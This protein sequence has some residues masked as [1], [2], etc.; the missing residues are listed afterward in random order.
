M[1]S[2]VK[3][4]SNDD[5]LN[6]MRTEHEKMNEE[7]EQ[8]LNQLNLKENNGGSSSEAEVDDIIKLMAKMTADRR[9][10]NKQAVKCGE[11]DSLSSKSAQKY[12]N[13]LDVFFDENLR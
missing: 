3:F 11:E 2:V 13:M 1:A 8:K 10:I 5:K 4:E 6:R 12:E 7:L 9:N